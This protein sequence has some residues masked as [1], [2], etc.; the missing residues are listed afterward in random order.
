MLCYEQNIKKSSHSQ[1]DHYDLHDQPQVFQLHTFI[2]P[3]AI[4]KI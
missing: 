2:K 4:K 3:L 1:R